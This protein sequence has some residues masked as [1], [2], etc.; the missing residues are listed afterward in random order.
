[1]NA[2]EALSQASRE[3]E[4][5]LRQVGDDDWDRPTPCT[6]WNV[7]QLANHLLLGTRMSVQLL[8]GMSQQEVIAGLGDDLMADST[9]PVADFT[10]LAT[11]MQE[12]FAG[13]DG[14]EGTVDH[15]MGEIPRTTFIGFRVMDNAVH[16]WDLARAIGADETLDP[17]LVKLLWDDIQPM[18]GGLGDL[19]IF[20]ESASGQIGE[21]AP[22]QT[23]YL[24][25]LGRRP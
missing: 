8:A 25:L 1:M 9:D 21:D 19:G 17:D 4:T 13:P 12:G 23:R 6:E 14:L 15:P 11:E 7:G 10:T 16:A 24:D 3:Y 20:G 2:L 5:R 18:A 22:L